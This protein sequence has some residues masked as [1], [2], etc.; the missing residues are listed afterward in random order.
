[1]LKLEEKN[2]VIVNQDGNL[3]E[4]TPALKDIEVLRGCE[5]LWSP[6]YFASAVLTGLVLLVVVVEVPLFATLDWT[7]TSVFIVTTFL[8]SALLHYY[9]GERARLGNL[10]EPPKLR[11]QD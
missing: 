6:Y 7:T 3:V 10:E 4:P 9:Y 11:K 8:I 2:V 5:I 1:M